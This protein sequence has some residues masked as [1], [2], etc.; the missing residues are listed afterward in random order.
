MSIRFVIPVRLAVC[1]SCPSDTGSGLWQE[2]GRETG[3][4]QCGGRV[5]PP[6]PRDRACGV[7]PGHAGAA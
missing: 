7:G 4:S 1:L 5:S 6:R 3:L 2:S